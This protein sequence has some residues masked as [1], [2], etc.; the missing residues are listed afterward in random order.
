MLLQCQPKLSGAQLSQRMFPSASGSA[1]FRAERLSLSVNSTPFFA[2]AEPRRR[3]W[4]PQ[5]VRQS[6]ALLIPAQLFAVAFEV[7]FHFA[8]TVAAEFF[9]HCRG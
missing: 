5:A 9:A 1:A 4:W 7:A 2:E 8:Q 6:R 3:F